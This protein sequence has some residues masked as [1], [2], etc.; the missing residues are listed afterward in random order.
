MNTNQP[1][2]PKK[3]IAPDYQYPLQL[4]FH[5]QIFYYEIKWSDKQHLYIAATQKSEPTKVY[6][7]IVVDQ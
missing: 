4:N 1:K 5:T 2:H 3:Q 7:G 6:T